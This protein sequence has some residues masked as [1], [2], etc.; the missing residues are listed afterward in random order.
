MSLTKQ[1]RSR[2]PDD[3]P[4]L[5]LFLLGELPSLPSP[6]MPWPALTLFLSHRSTG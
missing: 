2:N 1:T 5:Q 3:F 4:T 6:H